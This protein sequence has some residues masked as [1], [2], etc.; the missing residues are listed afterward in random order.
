M[1][2]TLALLPFAARRAKIGAIGK[3]VPPRL[4][5]NKDLEKMVETTD[6]WI[7]SRVGILERHVAEKGMATSDMA[8]EA[9]KRCLDSRGIVTTDVEAIV[10]ATVTPDMLFPATACLVQVQFT[11]CYTILGRMRPTCCIDCRDTHYQSR[12]IFGPLSFLPTQF[13]RLY[14]DH[15]FL[16]G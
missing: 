10:V 11:G 16:P 3:Y 14:Y 5:T 15:S 1:S 2:L 12:R 6:E 13:P 9:A 8:V 7:Y 4:L